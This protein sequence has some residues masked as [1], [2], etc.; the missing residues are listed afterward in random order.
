[1]I[2]VQQSYC[3]RDIFF[4]V[5]DGSQRF[6]SFRFDKF[7]Q[8]LRMVKKAAALFL[9]CAS[10]LTWV[11]C[12]TTSSRFLYVALPGSSQIAAYREDPNSGILT[13][14]VGSPITAGPAVHALVIHPSN[15]FL[16]A[17]NSGEGDVS[18]FTI[19]TAGTLTEV[20]PRTTVGTG[21]TLL[22]MDAAGTFLY[23]GNS[24]SYNISV[25]S[26]SSSNGALTPVGPPFPVGLTPINMALS[27]SG[28]V[29]YVT[30]PSTGAGL[31]GIIE[32]FTLNQGVPTIVTNSPFSTGINPYGL[33]IAP[34]GGFLYTANN[35]D[36]SISEFTIN[37]DGSLSQFASPLQVQYAG[38]L[39]LL[40]DKSGKYLY[41]ANQSSS[42]LTGY[43]V[44][45]NGAL[46][47][48]T[49]SPFAAASNPSVIASDPS[50]NYLFVGNQKS[51]VIQS[52]NLATSTGALTSV[53]TYTL[54]GAPTSFAVTSKP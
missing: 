43:S 19:S 35:I 45:S 54:P 31:P 32:A 26:I 30:G 37:S 21:P 51:P 16:Y 34:G 42:F 2:G 50:G 29:L 46:T 33:A 25:F 17:A 22:A 4:P 53:S 28:S 52:F 20:T 14:L 40:I 36:D 1:M 18:L 23:V 7:L 11:S 6:P 49:T 24:G 38:P 9:V 27:P 47:L 3:L 44:G 5:A 10:M 48:L 39:A 41:V 15:K 13:Q 12:V 8:E